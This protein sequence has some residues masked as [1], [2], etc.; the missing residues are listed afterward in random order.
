MISDG[1][2]K[3]LPRISITMFVFGGLVTENEQEVNVN[4]CGQGLRTVH[5]YS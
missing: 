1:H 3:Q 4:E 5:T 2:M